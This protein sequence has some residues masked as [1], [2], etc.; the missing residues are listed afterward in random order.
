MPPSPPGYPDVIVH[1]FTESKARAA[2]D[3]LAGK[4]DLA[5]VPY[6]HHDLVVSHP[7]QT[8][9][10]D[11][12]STDFLYVNTHLAPFDNVLV[13]RA[14]NYAVDRREFV[15]LYASGRGSRGPAASCCHRASRRIAPYCPYQ[16]GPADQ[17]T[18]VRTSRRHGG[19]WPSQARYG[20]TITIHRRVEPP[21]HAQNVWWPFPDYVAGV[22]RDLGYQVTVE[23]IPPDH[24]SYSIEDPAYEA[25]QLFTQFGWM[26][27]Y[28]LASTFYDHVA[29]CR[30]PNLH[31]LLQ[32]GH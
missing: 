21:D 22:L 12:A 17:P 15:R 4:A 19:S 6:E 10:F 30:H 8:H 20:A 29:S 25:Y 32:R 9:E 1:R 31:A 5:A 28:D 13:R 7:A 3:V 26:A 2:E 14:L 18:V 27:D 23:D 16:T 11:E 24:R